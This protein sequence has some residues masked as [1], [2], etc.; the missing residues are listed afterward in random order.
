MF[1][2]VHNACTKIVVKSDEAPFSGFLSKVRARVRLTLTLLSHRSLENIIS[3]SFR[4][5]IIISKCTNACFDMKM[6][7]PLL[8]EV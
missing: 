8:P 7:S 3:Y 5:S 4:L 6:C 1:S 2:S